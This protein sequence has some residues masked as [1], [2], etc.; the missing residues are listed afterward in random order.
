MDNL[1]SSKLFEVVNGTLFFAYIFLASLIFGRFLI[2]LQ[3][4]CWRHHHRRRWELFYAEGGP[5]IALFVLI[6]GE[7]IIRGQVWFERWLFNH[8]MEPASSANRFV[9]GIVSG[10]VVALLGSWCV[11]RNYG[12][13]SDATI[14]IVVSIALA[15]ALAWPW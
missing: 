2:K 7:G 10:V 3:R 11:A 9:A 5:A 14:T 1:F 12:S 4:H 15:L 6:I 13:R 8:H